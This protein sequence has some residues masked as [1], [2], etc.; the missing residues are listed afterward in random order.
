MSFSSFVE[1]KENKVSCR[2]NEDEKWER[3]GTSS[4]VSGVWARDPT[5]FRRV[6]LEKLKLVV[7]VEQIWKVS[8]R[9]VGWVV[10]INDWFFAGDFVE[11]NVERERAGYVREVRR[12]TNGSVPGR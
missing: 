11:Y 9:L 8:L 4:G 2:Q 3:R 5:A 7:V 10:W 1:T 6:V 12:R